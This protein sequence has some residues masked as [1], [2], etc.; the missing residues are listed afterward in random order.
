MPSKGRL[1]LDGEAVGKPAAGGATRYRE[2]ELNR[3]RTLVGMVFQQFNLF[4]HM[5]VLENVMEGPLFVPGRRK[6]EARETALRHLERVGLGGK[7]DAYPARLSGGQQQRVAIARALA[8][9]PEVLLFDEPTSSLDPELVGKVLGV[10]NDLS[11]DG[12]TMLRLPLADWYV[13]KAE[14]DGARTALAARVTATVDREIDGLMSGE[15]RRPA[16]QVRVLARGRWLEGPR[17]SHPRG[18]RERPMDE[19]AVIAK[20]R[21]NAAR[22]LPEP[23]MDRLQSRVLTIGSV[24]DAACLLRDCAASR[25]AG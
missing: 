3:L 2:A 16:G 15:T 23:A 25:S 10:I 7:V 18:G 11:D 12:R 14:V 5:T 6:A 19:A 13:G 17:L 8:M 9:E 22:A 4:P 24:E 1:I 21:A 20:F